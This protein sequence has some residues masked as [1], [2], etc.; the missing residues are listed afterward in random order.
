MLD[1]CQERLML[2][3]KCR[4]EMHSDIMHMCCLLPVMEGAADRGKRRMLQQACKGYGK[5]A[6]FDFIV[7]T[8]CW[9]LYV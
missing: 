8:E 5:H 2:C 6:G 9:M 3:R 7:D 4:M 1:F